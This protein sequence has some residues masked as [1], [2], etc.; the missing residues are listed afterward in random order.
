ML[1]QVFCS[2]RAFN[3]L[4]FLF[5]VGV[6]NCLTVRPAQAEERR[7]V[8][9]Q[10]YDDDC[11]L[12][13]L[14]MLLERA[15]I[16]ATDSQLLA[17]LRADSGENALSASDL[18][19]MVAGL[20]AGVQ[21]DVGFLPIA[22]S[23]RLATNEP[24]LVLMKPQYL[25]GQVGIIGHF[26][27]VEGRTGSD[28]LVADPVLEKRTRMAR[29][30]FAAGTHGKVINDQ[31]HIMV[32][33]LTRNGNAAGQPIAPVSQ[34]M[35]LR[36]WE[37]ANLLPRALPPG[38][39]VM[40]VSHV[41]QREGVDDPPLGLAIAGSASTT[42][43]NIARGIGNRT[44]IGLS[45]A[46]TAGSGSFRFPGET[47]SFDRNGSMSAVLQL[48]HIPNLVLPASLGLS[49]SAAIEFD[50]SIKPVAATAGAD[51]EYTNGRLGA[52]LGTELR[53]DGKLLA[54]VTPMVNY[55]LPTKSGFVFNVGLSAPYRV[56]ADRPEYELQ[57]SVHRQIG[58][59]F[60]ISA[61]FLK[62]IFQ[63]AGTSSH[64]FGLT[65]TY[66]VPRRFRRARVMQAQ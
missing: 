44:Q 7:Q 54:V 40:S 5:A 20:K 19:E 64:L 28:F 51:L 4:P 24:F 45:V 23:E 55:R 26:I 13:A 6:S 47:I 62:S 59:D 50:K 18:R 10:N 63:Q 21:L 25:Q 46:N 48:D 8:L 60:Q 53:F 37:Q 36:S 42:I 33:R 14:R 11:G 65:L 41:Q 56:G 9:Q 1:R 66:G 43:L 15:G 22:A 35:K 27:L 52:S 17:N 57:A 31:P 39:L 12:A 3:A 32:L 61:F 2:G 49:T 16:E 30:L 58:M 38:K 34:D 29:E